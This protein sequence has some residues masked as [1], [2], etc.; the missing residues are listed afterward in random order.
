MTPQNC[1]ICS[2]NITIY[3][4]EKKVQTEDQKKKKVTNVA[5]VL[6]GT[7]TTVQN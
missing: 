6:L 1:E 2:V 4:K 3:I 7:V 5:I